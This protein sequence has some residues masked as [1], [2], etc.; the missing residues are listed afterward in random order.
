[1][2]KNARMID[3]H[4]HLGKLTK[5]PRLTLSRMLKEMDKWGVEKACVLPIENPFWHRYSLSRAEGDGKYS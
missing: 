1:M 2:D 5:N 3:I 4:T